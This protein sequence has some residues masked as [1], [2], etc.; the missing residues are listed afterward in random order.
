[1]TNS[2]SSKLWNLMC[3]WAYSLYFRL[4]FCKVS[5]NFLCTALLFFYYVRYLL[6]FYGSRSYIHYIIGKVTIC[7]QEWGTTSGP[8]RHA[9]KYK[10]SLCMHWSHCLEWSPTKDLNK[11]PK[12]LFSISVYPSVWDELKVCVKPLSQNP[13]KIWENFSVPIWHKILECHATWS[14]HKKVLQYGMHH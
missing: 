3:L 2:L 4:F 7:S 13:S 11:L 9:I 12:V 14:L 5:I 1:M 6:I 8:I 10:F